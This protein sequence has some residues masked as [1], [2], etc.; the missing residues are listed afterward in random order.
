M[1]RAVHPDAR[2]LV[3]AAISDSGARMDNR[4]R[5]LMEHCFG[6][7][8]SHIR[9]HF[10][11]SSGDA[12]R[13]FGSLAFNI[14]RHVCFR[15]GFDAEKGDAFN[16]VLAHEI[17]HAVQR[18]R[19]STARSHR[20][21]PSWI[22]ESEA[23]VCAEWAVSERPV[24]P[25]TP[26]TWHGPRCWDFQGHYYTILWAS[27]A[28]GLSL[29]DAARTSFFAQMPDQV[30]ELDAIAAAFAWGGRFGKSLPA[31]LEAKSLQVVA[32][33][34]P[35]MRHYLTQNP[36]IVEYWQK[37][38]DEYID[39]MV[40]EWTIQTGLHGLT[41]R[42]AEDE[43]ARR[44]KILDGLNHQSFE[45]GLGLHPY[46]DS[47]AH[48]DMDH[49]TTMY[50]PPLGHLTEK[51]YQ[52]A[53]KD[54]KDSPHDPDNIHKRPQL[55]KAYGMDLYDLLVRRW[56][57]KKPPIER[58]K[59]AAELDEVSAEADPDMQI[60]SITGF[61]AVALVYSADMKTGAALEVLDG[62]YKPEKAP[63]H[64]MG[65]FP[66]TWA[67]FYA[68]NHLRPHIPLTQD[69][70]RRA[71]TCAAQWVGSAKPAAVLLDYGP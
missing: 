31:S 15:P 4:T 8:L 5:A 40:A 23:D 14:D 32:Y 30:D 38:S 34:S 49:S 67:E 62:L 68:E 17:A 26:D 53:R 29:D 54:Y 45:F 56:A 69:L 35:Q 66:Q 12:N 18:E 39:E 44:L 51:G 37:Q 60:A 64:C 33:V 10:S 42:N 24:P 46:G 48:R 9:L 21:A 7:D 65:L 58:E 63:K 25:L 47:F 13:A 41:G 57:I 16:R 27:L 50:P 11:D 59:F 6:T 55:Y 71:Q 52:I 61:S 28:A 19:G 3:S 43:T 2:L 70:L 1:K 20:R 36:W 22:F